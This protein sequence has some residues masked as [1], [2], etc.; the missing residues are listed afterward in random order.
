MVKSIMWNWIEDTN[1]E[2]NP[3]LSIY[4]R[5]YGL[6]FSISKAVLEFCSNRILLLFQ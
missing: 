5:G 6:I 4:F 2:A 3:V 1:S